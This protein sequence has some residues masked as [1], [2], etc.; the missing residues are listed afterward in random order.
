MAE[1]AAAITLEMGS[2]ADFATGFHAAAPVNALLQMIE[3]LESYDFERPMGT[4]QI[5]REPI[6]VCGL[7]SPWNV[8]SARS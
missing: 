6:G 7:I 8:P 5:V 2:P 4:T 3:I 1:I